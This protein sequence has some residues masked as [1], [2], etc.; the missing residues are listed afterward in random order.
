MPAVC[1][2][3]RWQVVATSTDPV[4]QA[5]LYVERT[6]TM[7]SGPTP[8]ALC[9]VSGRQIETATGGADPPSGSET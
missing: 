6:D 4:L 2:D 8:V 1:A 3:A 9:R 5:I 7:L